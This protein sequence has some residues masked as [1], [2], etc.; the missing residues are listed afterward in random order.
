MSEQWRSMDSAPRD[1]TVILGRDWFVGWQPLEPDRTPPTVA[2]EDQV[3][4]VAKAIVEEI[5]WGTFSHFEPEDVRRISRAAIAALRESEAGEVAKIVA[6]LRT[7]AE[8]SGRDHD[9][10][11]AQLLTVADWLERGDHRQ[12]GGK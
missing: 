5:G 1:G 11:G 10:S 7:K 4:R 6:W 3:E 2:G 8:T 12:E 9:M